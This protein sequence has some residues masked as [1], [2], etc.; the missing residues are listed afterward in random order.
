MSDGSGGAIIA[1]QDYR[2]DD[3]YDIYAQRV[4]ASGA[5]TDPPSAASV[6]AMT[7]WGM[8]F[9][10]LLAGLGSAY[11]LKRQNRTTN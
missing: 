4:D 9:F 1:W 8:I 2:S 11:Y 5:L 7:G 6:P 3:N 10:M